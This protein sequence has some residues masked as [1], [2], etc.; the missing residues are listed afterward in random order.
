MSTQKSLY[1]VT[2]KEFFQN[3]SN[4]VAA[5]SDLLKE[6]FVPEFADKFPKQFVEEFSALL[7]EDKFDEVVSGATL[8]LARFMKP[9]DEPIRFYWARAK[10]INETETRGFLLNSYVD[11]A[12]ASDGERNWVLSLDTG[13]VTIK[14]ADVSRALADKTTLEAAVEASP[15]LETPIQ[16]ERLKEAQ[17]AVKAAGFDMAALAAFL[18]VIAPVLKEALNE[19]VT[20]VIKANSPAPVVSAEEPKV[21]VPAT[22]TKKEQPVVVKQPEAKRTQR[23]RTVAAPAKVPVEPTVATQEQADASDKK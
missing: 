15:V 22:A 11:K 4:A 1:E 14:D 21:E 19:V 10:S 5:S 18:P 23:A 6:L 13:K 3:Y 7:D 12:V 8:Y 2:S 17:A 9:G 20:Q 16:D